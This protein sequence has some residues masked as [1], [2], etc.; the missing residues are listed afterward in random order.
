MS[1]R[2]AIGSRSDGSA[3]STST[4]SDARPPLEGLALPS[5]ETTILAAEPR[6]LEGG[7]VPTAPSA[8]RVVPV[9][10]RHVQRGEVPQR[11]GGAAAVGLRNPDGALLAQRSRAGIH[12]NGAGAAERAR[13]AVWPGADARD[14]GLRPEY[15][16][17]RQAIRDQSALRRAT[18]AF[19][20]GPAFRNVPASRWS[21]TQ[22]APDAQH[23]RARPSRRGAHQQPSSGGDDIW[24]GYALWHH[25][26]PQN[27]NRRHRNA[28]LPRPDAGTC[29]RGSAGRVVPVEVAPAND[30]RGLDRREGRHDTV[31]PR[32][33]HR[34]AADEDRRSAPPA[35]PRVPARMAL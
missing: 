2:R 17:G 22:P 21:A 8:A 35:R 27:G 24:R 6:P 10:L 32:H 11:A 33:P 26:P 23:L 30:E 29:R 19:P 25:G 3:T 20:D 14:A 5:A 28:L 15:G 7:A 9:P 31:S 13:R 12:G 16:R 4:P 1:P 34:Q 18:A